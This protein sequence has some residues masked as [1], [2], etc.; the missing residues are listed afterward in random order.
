MKVFISQHIVDHIIADAD[1]YAT[2]TGEPLIGLRVD[3]VFY[4]LDTIQPDESA[5]RQ[6]GMFAS[7]DE[8]QDQCLTQLSKAWNLIRTPGAQWDLGLQWLGDWHKHPG[9]MWMPSQGDLNTARDLVQDTGSILVV[10]I[11]KAGEIRETKNAIFQD[12][13]AI[14][15]WYL[16]QDDY[17][18]DT[19]SVQVV[20]WLPEI[21]PHG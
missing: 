1:K 16:A 4:I 2:E 11:C 5:E 8:Y 13:Y 9:F 10:I 17:D 19:I 18:F 12:N 21:T 15:F 6:P 20:D 3:K 14:N 7:G